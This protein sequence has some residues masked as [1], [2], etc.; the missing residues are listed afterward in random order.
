M[1]SFDDIIKSEKPVLV[2][3]FAT[4][5]GPCKMMH[6]VLEELHTKVGEKARILKIDI[7]KNQEL[8]ALYNVRSVPT[9][10]IFQNGEMKWRSS[11]AM[12]LEVLEQ[13]LGK[14]F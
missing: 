8:A 6:P 7:D 10:M 12:P 5:C 11:G 2:D 13:E 14:Y 9:F 4:W 3:F 1:E